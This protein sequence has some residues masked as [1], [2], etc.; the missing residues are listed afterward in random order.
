MESAWSANALLSPE[1]C[2]AVEDIQY[3]FFKSGCNMKLF[4]N[5]KV[6]FIDSVIICP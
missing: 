2:K 5:T 4:Q 6:R 1:G 3:D